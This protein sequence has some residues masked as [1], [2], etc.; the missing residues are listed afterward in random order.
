MQK[1]IGLVGYVNKSELVINLAKTLSIT[2]KKV[3]VI[4]GTLEERLRYTIPAFNNSEKEYLTN[5]D[6][7]D[8]AL[9]F[10][11]MD[12]IKEYI[13]TKTSDADT[14]DIILLD[15]DNANAYTSFRQGMDEF[16]KT[17]FF[18]EYLNIS[19]GRNIEILKALTS[20]AEDGKKPILSRV[21]YKQYVSRASDKYFTK[22]IED[23]QVEWYERDYELPFLEQDKIADIEMQQSGYID[24][25]RHTK[26]FISLMAD[27]ASDMLG[28]VGSADIKKMLKMYTRGRA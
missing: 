18:I 8:Y 17:Y 20:F 27:M 10:S 23:Y 14:Y 4:D 9:G 24:L 11:S 7:V 16:T 6:G 22:L 2:G 19:F 28:D 3:L 26:Q 13:C 5:F 15:I 25:N 21:I 12:G 1:I